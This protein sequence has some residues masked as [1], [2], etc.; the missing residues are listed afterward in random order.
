[1]VVGL[2]DNE[3]PDSNR[4]TLVTPKSEND[5]RLQATLGNQNPMGLPVG[6]VSPAFSDD[7]FS[8]TLALVNEKLTLSMNAFVRKGRFPLLNFYWRESTIIGFG[9]TLKG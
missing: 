5:V 3:S 1:M 4:L 2:L 8:F 7:A 6:A 9:F